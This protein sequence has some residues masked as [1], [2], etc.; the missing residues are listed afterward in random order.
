[1]NQLEDRYS[2]GFLDGVSHRLGQYFSIASVA[3]PFLGKK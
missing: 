1:M 2:D 3:L